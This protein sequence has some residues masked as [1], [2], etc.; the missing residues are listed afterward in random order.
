[1]GYNELEKLIRGTDLQR[2]SDE[3]QASVFIYRFAFVHLMPDRSIQR[4][5]QRHRKIDFFCRPRLCAFDITGGILIHDHV[6]HAPS[7]D[8]MS[9][10]GQLLFQCQFEQLFCRWRH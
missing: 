7:Q 2:H 4:H 1:M 3:Q 6:I 9:A 10:M 8:W 5:D